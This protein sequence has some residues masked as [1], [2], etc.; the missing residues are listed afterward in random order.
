MCSDVRH[1]LLPVLLAQLVAVGTAMGEARLKDLTVDV[2]LADNGDARITETRQMTVEDTGTECYVVI[3]NL[4]GSQIEDVRVTDETGVGYASHNPWDTSRTRSA[5]TAQWGLVATKDGYELCWG[6]GQSGER[7]YT[8]SYTVTSLLRSYDDYDGFNYMFVAERLSPPAEHATVRISRSGGFTSDDVRMWAFRFSGDIELRDGVVCAETTDELSG[9]QAMI[10]M[11]QFEKG[12][13]HPTKQMEGSF[14]TVK[15]RAFEGS[16]YLT[17]LTDWLVEIG[18]YLYGLVVVLF[19][20]IIYLWD[21]VR[22]W[23]ARR[24]AFKD[25][26]WFRDLPYNGNLLMANQVLNA[27]RYGKNDY[28]SLISALVLRLISIGALR[29]EHDGIGIGEMKRE[30]GLTNTRALRDL[31]GIFR[32]A[33]GDDGVL[34][35]KELKRW[36]K[37]NNDRLSAFV[38]GI[39]VDRSVKS[40][41]NEVEKVREVFGLRQFL[42]DFT[43]ANERHASEVALWKDY[44]IYAELFGIAD[45]VRR[46][47]QRL[48]PDYFKMDEQFGQMVSRQQLPALL[49]ITL[50]GIN[51]NISRLLRERRR[52]NGS[53]GSASSGG[54]GGYSGGGSGGGIR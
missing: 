38:S 21:F 18:S 50:S 35:P 28:K 37:K 46:D 20:P 6:L 11:L 49:N 47:M 51:L 15:E 32:D 54:G 53:G 13:F 29:I 33:A 12:L 24:K 1:R 4:N 23:R 31:H 10:V 40:Y 22:R 9:S 2:V 7:T 27:Y 26:G 44:L 25:L 48:N 8:V 34:Q 45:Q 39:V 14:E 52:A 3:G 19:I 36:M 43:L 42:K 5:K 17:T 41:K 16:D 30:R